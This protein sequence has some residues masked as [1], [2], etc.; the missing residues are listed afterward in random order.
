MEGEQAGGL[1][2]VDVHHH[3]FAP[4]YKVEAR[5]QINRVAAW[6]LATR[7][8]NWSPEA[9][10]EEMDRNGV[11]M[12]VTST[13]PPRF[14]MNDPDRAEAAARLV[15]ACNEFAADLVRDHPSRFG[16]FAVLPLPD[17]DASLAELAYAVDELNADGVGLQTNYDGHWLGDPYFDPIFEELDRRRAVVHVHPVVPVCCLG[18]IP[19]IP[20]AML[21]LPF[22]TTRAITSLLC[23]DAFVRFPNV[24][25][26]FSHGGGAVPMMRERIESTVVTAWAQA[27]KEPSSGPLEQ[28]AGAFYDIVGV[29]NPGS[30]RALTAIVPESQL[31][32]GSD[33]PFVDAAVTEQGLR[34]LELDEDAL[35]RIAADNALALFPRISSMS[36]G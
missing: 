27:G 8:L 11:A 19:T 2:C 12:A 18:L 7:V 6:D 35:R 34:A 5:E 4:Q 23:N 17:I 21:E 14:T 15:R 24:R 30:F 25:L 10:L 3:V 1:R 36:A 26:I 32:F 22:D 20:D 13:A 28:F 9:S 31:A 33:F 16:A 29:T